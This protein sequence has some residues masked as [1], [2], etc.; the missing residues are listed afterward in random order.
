[1]SYMTSLMLGELTDVP[2]GLTDHT[3]APWEQQLAASDQP[4]HSLKIF[5]SDQHFRYLLVHAH[6]SAQQVVMLALHEFGITDSS[7]FYTLCEVTVE[8]GSDGARQ[9]KTNVITN[10]CFQGGFVKQKRLSEHQTNLA[11]RIGLASRY[12]IKNVNSSEQLIPEDAKTELVKES[13]VNLLQLNPIET[14]TQLMVEDFTVFRMIG[15]AISVQ[16]I[17]LSK[18][19]NVFSLFCFCNVIK[20]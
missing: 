14:A 19:L 9:A 5:R 12:Y 2:A 17:L 10:G 7:T 18:Y 15:K 16:F 1:M 8:V 3:N 13:V 20:F 11:E 4:E 6:T